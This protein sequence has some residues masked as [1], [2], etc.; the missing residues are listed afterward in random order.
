MKATTKSFLLTLLIVI[1]F[2]LSSMA[3]KAEIQYFRPYGKDGAS[4]FETTKDYTP[5]DGQR[6]KI[7]ANF[8][9]Q[10]QALNSSN[11]P[12]LDSESNLMN[13]IIKT[14]PGFNLATANLNIDAQ[15]E[16]GIRLNVVTYLSSRHHSEAWVKGGY[17]QFDKLPFLNSD[18]FD[19]IMEKVTIKVGHME[20]NYGDGHFRRTDNGN[21]IYNPF[22]GNYILDAFNTEIG[23]EIYYQDKGFLAMVGATG[24][25][26]NGNISELNAPSTDDNARR[27]PTY[28]AKVAYNVMDDH[29]HF[30]ISGSTYYTASSAANH[31]FDGDRSGSRYYS[32]MTIPG[33]RAGDSGWFATGRYDPGYDDEVTAFQGNLFYRTN[34]I[35]LFGLAEIAKGRDHLEAEA[36]KRNT[37]Q[38]AVEGLY[39]FGSTDNFYLGAR[40]NTLS[41]DDPSGEKININRVQLGAGW[42]LTNN[43]LLKAEY[44]TQKYNDFAEESIYNNGKFNGLLIEATVGF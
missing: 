43:I 35:E 2:G 20:I 32:V 3:Q 31:L 14:K 23:A 44:V 4:I 27:S 9:Q 11:T 36:D 22:V 8:T 16:D 30:R 5:F 34:G 13:E 42:F 15:L 41:A 25:E 6:V 19:K 38:I 21:A 39:R 24:G 40:Y 18:L 17:I 26:I 7:G 37:S 1:G 29:S 33:K 28:L 10:F 12:F